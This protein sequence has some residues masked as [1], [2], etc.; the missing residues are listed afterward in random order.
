MRGRTLSLLRLKGGTM[1]AALTALAGARRAPPLLAGRPAPP[2]PAL[3]PLI[4]AGVILAIGVDRLARGGTWPSSDLDSHVATVDLYRRSLLDGVVWPYD[5]SAAC[6][7]DGTPYY[8][9]WCELALGAL[10]VL[11]GKLG[12]AAPA[13]L[14]AMGAVVAALTALPLAAAWCA[15]QLVP[16]ATPDARRHVLH[17]GALAA[18]A[19]LACPNTDLISGTGLDGAVR[20]GMVNQAIGWV[21]LLLLAGCCARAVAAPSAQRLH[22]PLAL[23]V[24]ALLL[25]HAQTALAAALV[26]AVAAWRRPLVLL[27]SGVVGVLLAAGS[28]SALV[29]LADRLVPIYPW[30]HFSG[31]DPLL[32][33]LG[34]LLLGE[35]AS[36]FPAA[37]LVPGLLLGAAAHAW[38]RPGPLR[39]LVWAGLLVSACAWLPLLRALMPPGSQPYRFA[40]LGLLV[41]LVAGAAHLATQRGWWLV[42]VRPAV[43]W[44]ALGVIWAALAVQIACAWPVDADEDTPEAVAHELGVGTAAALVPPGS[45]VLAADTT[46]WH[47][48]A[49][50]ALKGSAGWS[51]LNA[52]HSP[53]A[54]PTLAA[55]CSAAASLDLSPMYPGWGPV[56][57]AAVAVAV[58]RDLGVTHLLRLSAPGQVT[59]Q[60]ASDT[61]L[62]ALP[63][64]LRLAATTPHA[65]VW[66]L[67]APAAPLAA[68]PALVGLD[69]GGRRDLRLL[70]AEWWTRIR[71]RHALAVRLVLAPAG[72][73]L[74]VAALSAAP[75]DASGSSI[76]ALA[77]DGL[78]ALR[79]AQILR[80]GGSTNT[81]ASAFV[82]RLAPAEAFL[83]A[84]P[85]QPTVPSSSPAAAWSADGCSARLTGLVPGQ[86]YLWRTSFSPGFASPQGRIL[87]E[88]SGLTVVVSTGT[89]MEV[90]FSR[91]T[92]LILFATALSALTAIALVVRWWCS[93]RRVA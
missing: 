78:P 26:L 43:R 87:E 32:A 40:S 7:H 85:T 34:P 27:V 9:W 47:R 1:L 21:L 16:A 36:A 35:D 93:R 57:P 90:R 65:R 33:V 83:R 71:A 41:L 8:G 76:L 24:A 73:P 29:V 77:W 30:H 45:R 80:D 12:A 37:L 63:T 72:D 22:A 67:A 68:V 84:L 66:T 91:M 28:L 69:L 62:P 89:T 52:A 53:S 50:D 46:G 6:G 11:A 55:G 60:A 92:P 25:C 59:A 38:R 49:V 44:V 19:W 56:M 2:A 48:W 75:G 3:A 15:R 31:Y 4:A 42:R 51:T 79:S 82:A 70:A 5:R 54:P 58:L 17:A 81:L 14:V 10:A 64:D 23:C 13:A 86:P 39:T 74:L 18:F 61:P 88:V 20:M